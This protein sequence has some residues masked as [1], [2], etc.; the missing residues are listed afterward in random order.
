MRHLGVK[1][2]RRQSSNVIGRTVSALLTENDAAS[3]N[4]YATTRNNVLQP[5]PSATR[6]GPKQDTERVTSVV[7]AEL[8]L[9]SSWCHG[10][11]R[12]LRRRPRVGVPAVALVTTSLHAASRPGPGHATQR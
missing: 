2:V 7:P 8:L 1:P 12:G 5:S 11:H 9:V 6:A 3:L 4:T 10:E